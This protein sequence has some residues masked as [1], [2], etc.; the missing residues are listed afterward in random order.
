M[1]ILLVFGFLIGMV[2]I[3]FLSTRWIVEK[4]GNI[5]LGLVI[6][7]VAWWGLVAI[8]GVLTA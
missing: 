5:A 1:V 8:V 2:V 6:P 4:T 3:G 7:Q